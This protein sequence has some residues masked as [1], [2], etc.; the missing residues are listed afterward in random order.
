MNLRAYALV[1][2]LMATTMVPSMSMA[3]EHVLKVSIASAPVDDAVF[4]WIHEFERRVE[5]RTEGRIDVQL[6]YA[7]QLGSIPAT[8]EGVAMGTVEVAFSLV[9][10]LS[11][12]D[13]RYQVLDASGLFDDEAHASRVFR[14]PE[15]RRMFSEF[16]LQSDTELFALFTN[17]QTALASRTPVS[18]VADFSGLKIRTGGATPLVNRPLENLGAAPV[19]LSLGEV[20]PSIQTGVLDGAI[21]NLQVFTSFQYA[22]VAGEATYLPGNFLVVS[23]LISRDFL[24]RLGPELEAIVREEAENAL[25]VYDEKSPSDRTAFEQA[26][27]DSGGN[28]NTLSETESEFFLNATSAAVDE[29]LAQDP[30]LR[31]DY[32]VLAEAAERTR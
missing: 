9:G 21:A 24:R 8:I 22:D 2:V 10:F 3:Q 1:G 11:A 25:A 30:R 18:E 5:E 23:A 14:D 20:L 26:W 12:V 13:P 31:A 15:V 29:V 6:Y 28:L 16:G 19:S 17:G 32:E 7:G 27:I 4:G